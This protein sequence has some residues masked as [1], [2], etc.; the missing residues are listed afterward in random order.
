MQQRLQNVLPFQKENAKGASEVRF[1]GA[2]PGTLDGPK[3]HHGSICPRLSDSGRYHLTQ[4]LIA[5]SQTLKSWY[6]Y[7]HHHISL[8]CQASVSH[9][10]LPGTQLAWAM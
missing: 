7:F 2:D 1:G 3:V 5:L 4:V 8:R 6:K 10:S 9:I